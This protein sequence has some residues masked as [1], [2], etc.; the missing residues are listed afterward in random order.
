MTIRLS[1]ISFAGMVRTLVAVGIDSEA[2]MF[3]AS[4]FAMPR[5]GVTWSSF[6]VAGRAAARGASAGIAASSGRPT[7]GRRCGAPRS[8]RTPE[9][10]HPGRARWSPRSATAPGRRRSS[11]P[12]GVRRSGETAGARDVAPTPGS[13]GASEV[14]AAAPFVEAR[15]FV[16]GAAAVLGVAERGL[17]VDGVVRLEHRPPG[18]VH[19]V[20]VRHEPLVQLVD[21]PLVGAELASGALLGPGQLTRHGAPRP[22]RLHIAASAASEGTPRRPSDRPDGYR[23]GHA[24]PRGAPRPR[25]HLLRRV[26]RPGAV[27]H[28]EP[29]GRLAGAGGRHRRDD[30]D[31]RR[32]HELGDRT[33]VGGRARPA[34]RPR[35][36]A[37]GPARPRRPRRPSPG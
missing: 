34:R 4:A 28:A 14:G 17:A 22:L 27:R 33:A 1:I 16:A 21:E 25:P 12:R 24:F 23:F 8:G 36:A 35:R 37:P 7:C 18:P 31:R 2:S 6:A 10:R 29:A 19:R 5:S 11:R 3:V 20:P 13:S 26:P 9:R 15:A 30:P 32:E